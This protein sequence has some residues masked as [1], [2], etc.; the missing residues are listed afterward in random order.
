MP[1]CSFCGDFFFKCN[2]LITHLKIL[3]RIEEKSVFAC[4]EKGCKRHFPNLKS[5]RKHIQ[6]KHASDVLPSE[7]LETPETLPESDSMSNIVNSD[8]CNFVIEQSNFQSQG[9]YSTTHNEDINKF[10]IFKQKLYENKISFICK[11][12]S[13]TMLPR[14]SVQQIIELI[15]ELLNEPLEMFDN[16][17]ST[18]TYND[19]GKWQIRQFLAEFR[20]LFSGFGSE[21]LR[22]KM[23]EESDLLIMP[24]TFKVGER[25]EINKNSN[26]VSKQNTAQFVPLSKVLK[27]FFSLPG[28]LYET[29]KYVED[30]KSKK[31]IFNIVQ[32][33][34]WKNKISNFDESD[35][36]FPIFL[37]YDDY[38]TGNPLGSH[39]GIQKLGAIYCSVACLPPKYQSALENIFLVTL[40]HSSDFKEFGANAIF[41]RLIEELNSLRSDGIKVTLLDKE[42]QIYFSVVLFLANVVASRV[43][44]TLTLAL[45]HQLKLAS[46]FSE[47]KGFVD[48]LY[49]NS[50]SESTNLKSVIPD[51][52]N[53]IKVSDYLNPEN[54]DEFEKEVIV[55]DRILVGNKV[56]S[57]ND[58]ILIEKTPQAIFGKIFKIIINNKSQILCLYNKV[59][60]LGFSEHFFSYLVDITNTR[61]LVF[62]DDLFSFDTYVIISKGGFKYISI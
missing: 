48:Q 53:V 47:L 57:K 56:Y 50:K 39:S 61:N 34:L 40:F 17:F 16:I 52:E 22:F 60:T 35:I 62:F 30:L 46:R 11:L 45:K 19:Q 14:K 29:L 44:I 43:N 18:F 5:Y 2:A 55:L 58:V 31:D 49:F 25:I 42:Y 20:D 26:V 37:Y 59:R 23:L 6:S 7:H 21:Y 54:L 51:L 28:V 32:S 36:V 24:I 10:L 4:V 27:H 33:N 3:H 15:N 38:E 8:L 13:E 1:Q 41:P 9:E 12:Y